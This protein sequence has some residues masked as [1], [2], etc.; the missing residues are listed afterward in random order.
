LGPGKTGETVDSYREKANQ[1]LLRDPSLPGEF[2]RTYA[3]YPGGDL[4]RYPGGLRDFMRG[5]CRFVLE[6]KAPS[7]T[8]R[9]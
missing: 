4:E 3:H 5:F 9:T 7:K 8:I 1:V 6:G 2:S